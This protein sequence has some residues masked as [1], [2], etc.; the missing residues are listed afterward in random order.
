[1]SMTHLKPEHEK[2][3]LAIFREHLSQTPVSVFAFGS[4]TRPSHRVD[5]DLDLLIHAQ[6]GIPL[7]AMAQLKGAFEDSDLPFRVDIVNRADVGLEFY[8][9]IEK[10]L[11]LL[12]TSD[13]NVPFSC[14]VFA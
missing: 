12:W 6:V 8:H 1:M 9:R 5:S 4:Q 10:D 2:I 13:G 14:N 3:L 11:T 7:S